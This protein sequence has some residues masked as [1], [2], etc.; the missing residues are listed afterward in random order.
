MHVI[1][2]WGHF[3][4]TGCCKIMG[5]FRTCMLLISRAILFIQGVVKF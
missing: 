1:N 3:I 4:Y 2:I 5:E